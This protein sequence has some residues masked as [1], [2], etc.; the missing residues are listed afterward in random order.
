[1]CVGQTEMTVSG[2]LRITV[3]VGLAGG[4]GAAV[5]P[6]PRSLT[7]LTAQICVERPENNGVLNIRPADIVIK[8]GPGLSLA[9]G[10]AAC[11]YVEGGGKYALWAQSSNPYDPS[12]PDS[13]AWRSSDLQVSVEQ[14]GRVEL[15][16]CAIGPGATYENWSVQPADKPCP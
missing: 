3:V 5:S 16:L 11:A 1:M 6:W 13:A 2:M 8:G 10:E 15:L 4:L 7:N 12:A 9:G 14:G